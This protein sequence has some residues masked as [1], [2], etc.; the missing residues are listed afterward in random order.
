MLTIQ[1]TVNPQ[2]GEF[3]ITTNAQVPPPQLAAILMDVA[4]TLVLQPQAAEQKPRPALVVPGPQPI[5]I[6]LLRGG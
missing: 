3:Q 1:I 2:Q 6:D 4:K 5:P